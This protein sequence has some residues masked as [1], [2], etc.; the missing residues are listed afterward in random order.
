MSIQL[1]GSL[2]VQSYGSGQQPMPALAGGVPPATEARDW[3]TEGVSYELGSGRDID[4]AKALKCYEKASK[5]DDVDG[6]VRLAFFRAHGIGCNVN[7]LGSERFLQRA[8]ALGSETA[9]F[10]LGEAWFG[11]GMDEGQ[12]QIQNK[13]LQFITMAEEKGCK[14]ASLFKAFFAIIGSS[15]VSKDV[16][17]GTRILEEA[18]STGD[19]QALLDLGDL[20]Y[21][22]IGVQKNMQ[23]A[24]DHYRRATDY[25]SVVAFVK[26][27]DFLLRHTPTNVGEATISRCKEEAERNNHP[28]AQYLMGIIYWEGIGLESNEE[29]AIRFLRMAA[30]G[31]V[32]EAIPH[33]Q[34]LRMSR[35]EGEDVI[36]DGDLQRWVR[37]GVNV[38]NPLGLARLGWHYE[39]GE[40]VEKDLQKAID[41]YT[42]ALTFKFD[43]CALEHLWRLLSAGGPVL[44][45]LRTASELVRQ[46]SRFYPKSLSY[47]ETLKA[48]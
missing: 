9:M 15:V 39:L 8:V 28:G 44:Q 13:A 42:S 1:S 29:E 23:K 30:R 41:C 19:V 20:Y 2:P 31:G 16:Q 33:L 4:L 18:A 24:L 22:G 47:F 7:S 37:A 12:E 40:G 26:L 32:S 36:G 45:D 5:C 10:K 14:A 17:K 43:R 25:G 34:S 48:K 35:A 3:F 27:G 21:H 6:L 38:H 46:S 11:R